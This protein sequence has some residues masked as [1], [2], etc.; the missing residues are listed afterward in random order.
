V[1]TQKQAQSLFGE[2]TRVDQLEGDSQAKGLA[3]RWDK[4][5]LF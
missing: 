4:P 5:T 2:C 1:E 3:R